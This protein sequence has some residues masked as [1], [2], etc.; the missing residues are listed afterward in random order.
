[1]DRRA[2]LGVAAAGSLIAMPAVARAQQAGK[3]HR[4]G[5]LSLQSGLTST[6]EAFP[7][8]MRE[9][10]YVEGRNLIIEYRWAARKEER[11]PELAAELVR[12]KVEVIVTAAAPTIEAARRATSTIPIVMAT[13]ADPVGSGL[14]A[15]LARPG[16]NV[17]GLTALSTELAGKRLQ[18]ARELVPKATR[19]AVLAY[20]G[21]S[22]TRL[23]LEE[24]RA[25]AQQIGVQLVV[26]EVNETGDLTGAFTAMQRER[27]QALV[28]QVSPFSADNAKRI[29]ELAAQHRLPAMYDVRSF[30]DAG[31]LVSYGPSLPEMF[32][33]AAFYVDKILKGAKPADLPIEQPTKFE[34]VINLKAAKA[35][36]LTIPPALLARADQVIQ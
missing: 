27:A 18:L 2:F 12:L 35:L 14:V 10:G 5:F 21:S 6:T 24:M 11:L 19:V 22:V 29:V 9:L 34:L 1:M 36:G 23:F 3:V 8:E 28:V 30:V 25:A 32:R 33:R 7:K 26:Q 4:V 16:G 13:A 31:G 15:S 20:H 17:T